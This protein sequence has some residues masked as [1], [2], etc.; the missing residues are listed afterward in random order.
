LIGIAEPDVI[1]FAGTPIK[2][3]VGT[4]G[5]TD[6]PALNKYKGHFNASTTA[7]EINTGEAPA[8]RG[9]KGYLGSGWGPL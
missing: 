8:S 2:S 3:I 9:G 5:L 7:L 1:Q 4:E 6:N